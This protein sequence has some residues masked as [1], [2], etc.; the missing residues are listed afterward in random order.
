MKTKTLERHIVPSLLSAD[1]SNLAHDVKIIQEAGA[2]SVQL[3]VMDGHF[4]PNITAGPVVLES[5]RKHST[6]YLDVHLMIENPEKFIEVFAKAGAS[7]LTVHYEACKDPASIIK[8]IKAL[9]VDAGMAIR[10]KTSVSV[11]EPFLP[12]LDLALVMTVEPGFGGQAFMPDMLDK[13]R[14]LRAQID[15]KGLSCRLQVDGGIN[16]K[17][18]V[19]AAQAGATS[20]VAGSAVFGAPDAT[21]AFR[22]LQSLISRV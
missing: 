15:Q 17:T 11:F 6:I 5:L 4:V 8:Q 13:V 16:S 9:G 19:L 3:D 20:L 10:P 14:T 18:A 1:F 21:Q 12:L 2:E 7:L 22:S